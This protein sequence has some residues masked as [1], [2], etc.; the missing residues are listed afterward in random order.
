MLEVPGEK[1]LRAVTEKLTEAGV[2]V[3]HSHE[4]NLAVQPK[5][6]DGAQVCHLISDLPAQ[7]VLKCAT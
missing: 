6:D 5:Q 3:G 2:Q 7:V 4:H 1:E